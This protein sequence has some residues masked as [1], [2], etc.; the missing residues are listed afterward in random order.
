MH[1]IRNPIAFLEIDVA[2]DNVD[3]CKQ[4]LLL[5]NPKNKHKFIGLFV[6]GLEEGLYHVSQCVADA[7]S[8]FVQQAMELSES[9]HVCVVAEDTNILIMMLHH[10]QEPKHCV[11]LRQLPQ[12]D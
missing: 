11:Y 10:F 4:E 12:N 7:D 2:F 8:Y 3:D 6:E 9:S 1:G 5:S